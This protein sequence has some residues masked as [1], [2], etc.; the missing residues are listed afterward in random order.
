VLQTTAPADTTYFYGL[1]GGAELNASKH[2]HLR[3][4]VEFVHVFLFSGLLAD[5]RNSVRLSIGP[6]FSFG[7]NVA[8]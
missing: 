7:K 5:S 8:R 4:D 3:A 6:S 1:G 2:V